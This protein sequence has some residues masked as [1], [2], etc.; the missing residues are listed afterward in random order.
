MSCLCEINDATL[1]SSTDDDPPF[2]QV[3]EAAFCGQTTALKGRS[4]QKTSET[5]K[6]LFLHAE[7][8]KRELTKIFFSN[9][10]VV[11][12]FFN[13]IVKISEKTLCLA[14]MTKWYCFMYT[15]KMRDNLE[16]VSNLESNPYYLQVSV[17]TLAIKLGWGHTYL[18]FFLLTS[19]IFF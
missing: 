10:T 4:V 7:T 19:A 13:W 17:P 12:V 6:I 18:N 16:R 8:T 11:V 15:W 14:E 2:F 5:A 3:V 9:L 1:D